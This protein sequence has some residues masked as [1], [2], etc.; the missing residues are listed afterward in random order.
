MLSH[1]CRVSTDLV[2]SPIADR[3]G[4]SLHVD[5]YLGSANSFQRRQVSQSLSRLAQQMD[6]ADT[7]RSIARWQE[8]F[9]DE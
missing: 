6:V 3:T 1:M 9:D 8:W 7:Q 2:K 4:Q 5:D